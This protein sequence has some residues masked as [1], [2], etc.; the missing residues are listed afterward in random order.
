MK[1]NR[2]VMSHRWRRDLA[3]FGL[4]VPLTSAE[5]RSNAKQ[6]W[7]SA[8]VLSPLLVLVAGINAWN[9]RHAGDQFILL[10]SLISVVLTVSFL[11]WAWAAHRH[12]A[13]K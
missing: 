9:S 12:H 6:N 13:A 5:R 11:V 2:M 4:G 8:R 10:G 3:R 1:R 7:R